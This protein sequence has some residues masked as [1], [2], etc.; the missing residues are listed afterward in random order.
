[1][2]TG[3]CSPP[4]AQHPPPRRREHP[5][6][7]GRCSRRPAASRPEPRSAPHSHTAQPLKGGVKRGDRNAPYRGRLSARAAPSSRGLSK[8]LCG[9]SASTHR[10]SLGSCCSD[11]STVRRLPPVLPPLMHSPAC[12]PVSVCLRRREAGA[13]DTGT[14]RGQGVS[15]LPSRTPRRP[16]TARPLSRRHTPFWRRNTWSNFIMGLI[17]NSMISKVNTQQYTRFS[18]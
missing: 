4:P 12:P 9:L 5:E 1:M 13:G 15:L 10:P 18:S 6:P 3:G 17:Y 2:Y 7:G 11:T 16:G 8:M 14:R